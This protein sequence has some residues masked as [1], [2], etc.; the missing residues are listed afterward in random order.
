MTIRYASIKAVI[1][2]VAGMLALCLY[3]AGCDDNPIE[4]KPAKDYPAY[5]LDCYH[6]EANWYFVY[7]PTTNTVDSFWLPYRLPPF[8]S[9]DGQKMYVTA[10]TPT[11]HTD[12][13]NLDS[14]AVIDQFP[15]LGTIS[16]SPDNRLLAVSGDS[17]VILNTSG[18]SVVFQDTTSMYHGAFSSNSKRFYGAPRAGGV[19]IL[20]L[21]DPSFS[22]KRLSVPFGAVRHVAPSIDETKLFLYL[23]RPWFYHF[24]VFAVYDMV[25]DSLIFSD[26]LWSGCGELEPT[27]DGRYVFY[28]NPGDS[29]GF[30]GSPWLTIYDIQQNAILSTISTVGILEYPYEYGIPLSEICISPDGK[31]LTAIGYR[32]VLSLD[33]RRMKFVNHIMLDGPKN[34]WGLSCQNSPW[35]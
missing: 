20:D 21:S 17:L 3:F 19:Y 24:G 28:T 14:M 18:Y 16:F 12:V 35:E 29:Y 27:P 25:A 13:L 4:P 10:G 9:A 15:Y 6:E 26:T 8:I 11:D 34:L 2:I 5:F 7:H 22:V 31:W 23:Q 30:G 1:L 32:F 33:I